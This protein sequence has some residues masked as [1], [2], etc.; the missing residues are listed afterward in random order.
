V[1]LKWSGRSGSEICPIPNSHLA[2]DLKWSGR[3]GSE[4]TSFYASMRTNSSSPKFS[5]QG[6]RPFLLSAQSC[7]R[8][9]E[10]H[11][12]LLLR[13]C[14]LVNISKKRYPLSTLI[15]A[16]YRSV[17]EVS[18]TSKVLLPLKEKPQIQTL[19][20][21]DPLGAFSVCGGSTEKAESRASYLT[22]FTSQRTQKSKRIT[23]ICWM[24]IEAKS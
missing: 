6:K 13:W 16:P 23:E 12:V 1:H 17:W 20:D 15:G 7:S 2:R 21:V 8:L 19:A 24:I 3:S 5:L 4:T 11:L 10:N 9:E 22:F 14:S 18:R